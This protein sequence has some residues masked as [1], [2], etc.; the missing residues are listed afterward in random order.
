MRFG[1][2]APLQSS[3]LL[4]GAGP[5]NGGGW[6]PLALS[7]LQW[8][9]ATQETYA[10][11][12]PVGQ[13]TDWSGN[14]RHYTAT[15]SARPTFRA[16]GINGRAAFQSDGVDDTAVSAAFGEYQDWWAYI[17][18]Q[19]VT[20]AA[21]KELWALNDFPTTVVIYRLL[22]TNSA[23]TINLNQGAGPM[24]T[25]ITLANGV[26]RAI[27]L[28]GHPTSIHYQA[29]NGTTISK[30]GLAGL[31]PSTGND[32]RWG[33]FAQRLFARGDAS[34][35]FNVRIGELVMGSGT[36]SAADQTRLWSYFTAKWGTVTP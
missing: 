27:R 5:G 22:E 24:P 3:L 32:G 19:P 34:Q 1:P 8:I 7:P 31:Y 23:T 35:Y 11:G 26:T 12:D 33:N 15:G 28:E 13:L 21:T 9:D 16:T 29:D 14:G 4:T 30:T 25:S 18:C 20:M 2:P 36:L 17:V 10:E 6:T